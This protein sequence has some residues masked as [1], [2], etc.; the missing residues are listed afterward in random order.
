MPRRPLF[1]KVGQAS[2][3]SAHIVSDLFDDSLCAP[4]RVSEPPGVLGGPS[5]DVSAQPR[6]LEKRLP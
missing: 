5:I 1:C 6:E 3:V 2:A 4:D